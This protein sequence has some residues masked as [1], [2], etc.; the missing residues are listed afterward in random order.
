MKRWFLP[1]LLPLLLILPC[2]AYTPESALEDLWKELPDELIREM[3]DGLSEDL[4]EGNTA[5]VTE[6]LDAAF[7][8]DSLGNGLWEAITETI[9]TFLVLLGTLLLASL[10]RAAAGIGTK[11][12]EGAI[13]FV[14]GLVTLTV[15]F[16]ALKPAWETATGALRGLST[17]L[18]GALP[19]LTGLLAAA[20][21]LTTSAVNAAW[22]SALLTLLEVLC[23]AILSPLFSICFGFLLVT[24]LARYTE[25]PD[26][27]GAVVS[28]KNLCTLLLSLIGAVFTAVM[29]YQSSLAKSADTAT[30]RCVK[31]ASGNLIPVVGSALSEAAGSYL[32]SLSL[33]RH[34]AGTV[35]VIAVILLVLPVI[36]RLLVLR[37]V[38]GLS[39]ILAG[40]IG[41]RQEG[42]CIREAIGLLDL[43]LA[44]TAITSAIFL[45][46]LGLFAGMT[47]A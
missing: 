4:S 10:M 47:E 16:Q 3:P 42:D 33:I 29:T 11:N 6:K 8:L 36:L 44:L 37:T 39:G 45:V 38:F 26:L 27:S 1:L 31:F 15:I 25:A 7:L 19:V 23:Q 17:L 43:A 2:H 12:T 24:M 46:V 40:V 21:Q 28:V 32:S 30:L 14:A 5:A 20:G 35:T 18:T 13:G 34:T 9:D 22:L 41:C